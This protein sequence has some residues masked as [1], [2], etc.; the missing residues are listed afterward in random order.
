MALEAQIVGPDYAGLPIHKEIS[1][2]QR[3]HL[4]KNNL[5]CII[6]D[7]WM[8]LDS[9]MSIIK[10]KKS[11]KTNAETYAFGRFSVNLF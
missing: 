2:N 7:A 10:V 5:N 4:I 9:Y 8:L 3:L 1:N 6:D 11:R